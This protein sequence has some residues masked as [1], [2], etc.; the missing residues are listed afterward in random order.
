MYYT[1]AVKYGNNILVRG[2]ANGKQIK[3]K[4]QYKPTLFVSTTDTSFGYKDI[5][6]NPCCPIK[7]NDIRDA[8]DWQKV[9]KHTYD[10]LGMDNFVLAYLGD[11]FKN[12]IDF[13]LDE[14]RTDIIDIEVSA[15][16][17]P[18]PL[19]SKYPIDALTL[20]DNIDDVYYSWGVAPWSE[21][22][23]ELDPEILSKVQYYECGDEKSLLAKFIMHWSEKCPDVISGWN[24]DDF[25]LPYVHGRLEKVLGESAAN[26]LSPW[27]VVIVRDEKDKFNNLRKKI[28]IYGVSSL[29]Y[30]ALY[31]KFTY[32]P[33]A[34]YKLGYIASVELDDTKL[35]FEGSHENLAKTNYQKY[36]DYN[37]KDVWLV[38]K[39]DEKLNLFA[40]AIGMAYAARINYDDAFG[41]VKMW[42]AIIFN[43]LKQQRV[44]I[45][46]NKRVERQPYEG[47]YVKEPVPGFYEWIMSFDLTSLHPMLMNQYNISPETKVGRA[48]HVHIDDYVNKVVVVENP[49]FA[50]AANGVQY[51]KEF[52]GVI[53]T[54]ALKVFNKRVHHKNLQQ[55]FKAKNEL[56]KQELKKRG[57]KL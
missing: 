31:L 1:N 26:K 30:Y 9:N 39:L 36:I 22:K 50:T 21:R 43:E 10:I 24:S 12:D 20:Y 15:P 52:K 44:V 37:I 13:N 11:T 8:M 46:K 38:K 56:I 45:P 57:I 51:T 6:G 28:N 18:N 5:Y 49:E 4:V 33:R 35:E 16:E 34:F 32:T 29:D 3:Q 27:G 41:P 48:K 23:S 7:F 55:E 2:I 14:I 47:A 42:D 17:F 53:P 25:D 54:V 40:V 19:E